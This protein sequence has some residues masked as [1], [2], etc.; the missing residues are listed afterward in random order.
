MEKDFVF[1]QSVIAA[2]RGELVYWV[3]KRNKFL[4]VATIQ[5]TPMILE[6]SDF[7]GNK[8]MHESI[9]EAYKK[10]LGCSWAASIIL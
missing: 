3:F 2:R 4:P 8:E 5:E 9:K 1:I 6:I 10:F 7:R